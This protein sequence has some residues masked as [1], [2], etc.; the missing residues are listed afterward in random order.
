[1]LEAS[2]LSPMA[3]AVAFSA[4]TARGKT[5]FKRSLVRARPSEGDLSRISE[6]APERRA[7]SSSEKSLRP[8]CS[9]ACFG[10]GRRFLFWGGM[11]SA[12]RYHRIHRECGQEGEIA[13]KL[14]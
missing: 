1:M 5:S 12:S 8:C 2:W 4:G 11:P 6:R 3:R 7:Q 13:Q 10:P 9:P 14:L